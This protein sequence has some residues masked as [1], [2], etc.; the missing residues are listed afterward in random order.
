M[1]TNWHT[2]STRQGLP[3]QI[4][5]L[6]ITSVQHRKHVLYR[7]KETKTDKGT[8]GEGKT[9]RGGMNAWSDHAFTIIWI[10]RRRILIL[11]YQ[12]PLECT[13]HWNIRCSPDLYTIC[14]TSKIRILNVWP[15]NSPFQVELNVFSAIVIVLQ[16]NH[17]SLFSI[18]S[19]PSW[20]MPRIKPNVYVLAEIL[21]QSIRVGAVIQIM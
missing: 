6:N 17:L 3:K 21:M 19:F 4:F 11:E 5:N 18:L 13:E 15:W 16:I 12:K 10:S 20:L 1:E 14:K 2:W 7:W 8:D 9:E